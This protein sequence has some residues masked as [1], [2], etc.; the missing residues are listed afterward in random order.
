MITPGSPSPNSMFEIDSVTPSIFYCPAVVLAPSISELPLHPPVKVL[1]VTMLS[2]VASRIY[3]ILADNCNSFPHSS[4]RPDAGV[5][6]FRLKV[7]RNIRQL[8]RDGDGT[9]GCCAAAQ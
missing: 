5:H 7:R 3:T 1:Q 2:L 8:R 6:T 9:T 4:N